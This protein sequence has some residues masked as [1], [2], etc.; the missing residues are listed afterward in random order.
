M[1]NNGLVEATALKEADA[2]IKAQSTNIS[3]YFI[4]VED[5]SYKG[6]IRCLIGI[7]LREDNVNYLDITGFEIPKKVN[8]STSQEVEDLLEENKSKTINTRIPWTRIIE[9]EKIVLSFKK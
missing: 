7:K 2:R 6:K 5:P 8:F 9:I 3:A 1:S 4:R